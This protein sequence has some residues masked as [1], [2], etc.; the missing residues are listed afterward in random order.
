MIR[1]VRLDADQLAR[2]VRAEKAGAKL[3]PFERGAIAALS[4]STRNAAERARCAAVAAR[5][6]AA[7]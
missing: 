3:D 5:R 4:R 1:D 2:L 7:L 6:P